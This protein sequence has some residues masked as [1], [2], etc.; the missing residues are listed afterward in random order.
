[1]PKELPR[2]P[3][4]LDRD[5]GWIDL[6]QLSADPPV[7]PS[8][9]R[10]YTKSGGFYAIAPDGTVS[11]PFAASVANPLTT[12]GDIIAAAAGGTQTRL[13]VGSDTQV[14][15]AD[16]TQTLGVKW[17]AAGGGG[18]IT[19]TYYGYNTIGGSTESMPN[20]TGNGKTYLKSITLASAGFIANI[21]SYTKQTTRGVSNFQVMLYTDSSGPSLL[22][23]AA[24]AAD[25]NVIAE[26]SAHT[27]RWMSVPLGLWVAAGTYWIGVA[28]PSGTNQFIAYDATGSDKTFVT[29]GSYWDDIPSD[30]TLATTANQ[31]SIRADVLS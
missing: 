10:I 30:G 18:G 20:G 17:A 24:L 12:K 4:A 25:G 3:F 22:I 21:Q 28:C 26:T 1:M 5:D 29:S 2:G 7:P 11:G 9:R 13:A 15:T 8:G 23:A 19:H 6:R 27:A 14:L 31:Y 16:S